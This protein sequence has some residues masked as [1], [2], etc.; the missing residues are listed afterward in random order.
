MAIVAGFASGAVQAALASGAKHA[1]I[2]STLADAVAASVADGVNV[3][4]PIHCLKYGNGT[5]G[6]AGFECP[7]DVFSA[8]RMVNC[9]GRPCLLEVLTCE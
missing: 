4:A 6:C 9:N 8:R 7:S 5:N 1:E 2:S 3:S